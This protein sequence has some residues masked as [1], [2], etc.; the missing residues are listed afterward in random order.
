MKTRMKSAATRQERASRI[1][2]ALV[3]IVAALLLS[4]ACR[5]AKTPSLIRLIDVLGR[6]N[7]L[8]SPL[9]EMAADPKGFA[10]K[11]PNVADLAAKF[12]LLDAGSGK[13][14]FL[15]KK[16]FPI[17]P[18][19]D[20]ALLAPPRSTFRFK[21][22]IPP[23]S[24]LEFV[25]EVYRGRNQ[26]GKDDRGRSVEFSIR[27]RGQGP[28][29]LIFRRTLTL[30]PEREFISDSM[31]IDLAAY[32]G[33]DA[34]LEF[35]TRGERDLPALWLSP[36][37][38][39]PQP[40]PRNVILISLDTLRADHLGCY[41]Y[42]RATSPNIDKLASESVLF[43]NT[44]AASPWTL[45]SHV[46]IL[47]GL[48]CVNHRVYQASDRMDPGLPTLADLFRKRGYLTAAFTGGG[49][50]SGFYGFSKGF[51]TFRSH[52]PGADPGLDAGNLARKAIRWLEANSGKNFLLF[53]H[54][55]QMHDPYVP[56]EPYKAIFLDS[57]A[58]FHGM[59]MARHG[60]NYENRFKPPA[61]EAFRRNIIA[62]Y[63]AEIRYTDEALIGPLVDELRK[64]RLYDR[65]MIVLTS[66]HGE[67]FYEKGSWLHQG[68]IYEP[69]L[70]VPL[71]IKYP[72]SR[73]AGRRVERYAR[74]TDITPTILEEMGV[75]L[76]KARLDGKG[77][78]A[79]VRGSERG[80][81]R[82]FRS[83]L[84]A[85]VVRNHVPH[86]RAVSQ[87]TYKIIINDPYTPQDLSFFAAPPPESGKLE[88]YD[89]A[90]DPG[91]RTNLAP[92]RPEL[93]RRLL[94]YLEDNFKPTR[95]AGK[96]RDQ[97]PEIREDIKEELKALGYIR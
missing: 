13:N 9:L 96:V 77:L 64:L 3:L 24:F 62:L 26:S 93:A 85:Y 11:N 55:Y 47:T 78:G 80:E 6:E 69:V 28:G 43:R 34:I 30:V 20:N 45:P 2:S 67:E 4:S 84:A 5:K 49:F 94:K 10:R 52:G 42:D 33:Q 76:P 70:K 14:P 97:N 32:G 79:L 58:Q 91:E 68:D 59:D 72:G 51:E 8:D 48:D 37:I 25:Y 27:L 53:L 39:T 29:D 60:Y 63:D 41:G 90:A 36:V 75:D 57:G 61:S 92:S 65:T 12:P 7:I 74:S 44:F 23:G 31:K 18:A 46:S 95:K 19:E 66:D 35:L 83:E 17:G 54:T 56:P 1:V 16:K 87:G 22:R 38:F 71:L 81:E 73:D 21:L 88:I 86:K 50:V 82:M 15:I 89:L 40:E